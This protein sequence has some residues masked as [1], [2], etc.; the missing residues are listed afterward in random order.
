MRIT[1]CAL[2]IA[3]AFSA[4]AAEKMF[5]GK[6]LSGWHISQVNHHGNTKGWS[7]DPDGVVKV[8]QDQPGNGG[9]LL[10]DKKYKNFEIELE[11]KPDF[12]CDGGLFLR[13]NEK[14][15]AY[16]VMLDYVEGGNIGGIYGEGLPEM[17]KIPNTS[18]NNGWEKIWKKDS[19]NKI[20]A[21]ITGDTPRIIVW[22]N[23]KQI[24]DFTDVKNHLPDSAT[25]GMVA[26]Q[27][28]RSDPK[29]GKNSRWVAGGF[30]RYR[31]VKIKVLP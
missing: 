27:A 24:V 7:V 23:G 17:N 20:K 3:I 2:L 29:G 31:N 14:G 6:D 26:L 8:T 19:W 28:H 5:N 4:T 15:Q 9:I 22:M 12:G 10:T 13:S 16:Q 30:H 18:R 25:E 11:I 21:R 1:V